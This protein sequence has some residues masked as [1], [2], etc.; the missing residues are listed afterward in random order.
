[1][2]EPVAGVRRK[3]A[4]KETKCEMTWIVMPSQA[5]ALGTAFGGQVMAWIDVCAAVAAQ[6]FTRTAVVTA[7]MDHLSFEAPVK[8]GDVV[9]LQA[10]V[11]W[12]GRTSLEVGVKVE[13]ENLTTGARTK[14]STAYLTF[15]ALGD[16]GQKLEVPELVPESPDEQRRYQEAIRRRELRLAMRAHRP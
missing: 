12:A 3:V 11:N 1:M 14:T 2:S 9:V 4:P 15:V 6:R 10:Q 8:Q 7:A 13:S 16:D 5:N